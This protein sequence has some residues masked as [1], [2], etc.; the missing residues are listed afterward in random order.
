MD[1]RDNQLVQVWSSLLIHR[2]AGQLPNAVWL[3]RLSDESRP[4]AVP[5]LQPPTKG[6]HSQS[7][8]ISAKVSKKTQLI[9]NMLRVAVERSLFLSPYCTLD[10][11]QRR[12]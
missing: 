5:W 12:L 3:R 9:C 11:C 8:G 4:H 6:H 2:G 1:D 10:S 7:V